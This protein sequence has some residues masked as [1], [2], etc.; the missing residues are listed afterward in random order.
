MSRKHIYLQSIFLKS[1]FCIV[2][3]ISSHQC[4][5]QLVGTMQ[6]YKYKTLYNKYNSLQ[7]IVKIGIYSPLPCMFDKT[8]KIEIKEAFILRDYDIFPFTL[9]VCDVDIDADL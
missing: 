1:S 7:Q 2:N 3:L 4:K 6:W 8:S 5:V 9:K